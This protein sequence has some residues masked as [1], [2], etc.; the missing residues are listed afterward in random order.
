MPAGASRR[1]QVV[2]VLERSARRGLEF[3][4]LVDLAV[5]DP[6][7]DGERLDRMQR[8]ACWVHL[9][10]A[11]IERDDEVVEVVLRWA[12][13]L[14]RQVAHLEGEQPVRRDRA[15]DAGDAI[16]LSLVEPQL[17]TDLGPRMAVDREVGAAQLPVVGEVGE[18]AE[19]RARIRRVDQRESVAA[20][21]MGLQRELCLDQCPHARQ[22]V[23]GCT[24][25]GLAAEVGQ[26]PEPA[27]VHEDGLGAHRRRRDKDR[28]QEEGQPLGGLGDELAV[29]LVEPLPLGVDDLGVAGV[30][31]EVERMGRRRDRVGAVLDLKHDRLQQQ[32]V[33]EHLVGVLA[34]A[35]VQRLEL[36]AKRRIQC[37]VGRDER[38][39]HAAS[40]RVRRDC[41]RLDGEGP[42]PRQHRRRGPRRTRRSTAPSATPASSSAR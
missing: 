41:Q 22:A 3:D 14:P 29:A 2:V 36:V 20:L 32:Q 5:G 1:D 37:L 26:R 31:P 16:L 25:L 42:Q 7:R 34:E 38:Q 27:Q 15:E 6:P 10:G 24:A 23:V 19:V 8:R 18:H 11:L 35:L 39:Q 33:A 40:R 9:P 28:R 13:F 4:G 17:D 30:V 21:R 12:Q